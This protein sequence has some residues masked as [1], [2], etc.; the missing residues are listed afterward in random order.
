[1]SK[2]GSLRKTIPP[3]S[4]EPHPIWRGIGCFL[5]LIL[6]PLSYVIS[7]L[8]VDYAIKQG[9]R[10]PQ[11]LAGYPVMPELLF[12]VP[13]LVSILFWIQSIN[14]LYANLLV[15]FFILVLLG[16]TVALLYAVMYRVTGP[17]QHSEFDAPPSSRK[18]K[19]YRR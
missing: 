7:L 8:T 12:S 16:V 6:P 11:G 9:I 3:K 18:V 4:Y 14:N 13:G 1:M 19:K 5:M 10:L 15:A 2:Y 17:P